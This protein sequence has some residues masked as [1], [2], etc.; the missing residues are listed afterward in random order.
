[1]PD[2]R[3]K[4]LPIASYRDA[5]GQNSFASRKHGARRQRHAAQNE[6]EA[7]EAAVKTAATG[8]HYAHGACF[9]A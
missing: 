1:M 4:G 2:S 7:A 9:C 6:I 3:E 8:F 5:D